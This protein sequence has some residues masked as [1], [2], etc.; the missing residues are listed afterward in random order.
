MTEKNLKCDGIYQKSNEQGILAKKLLPSPSQ[1]IDKDYNLRGE[2]VKVGVIGTEVHHKIHL[3]SDDMNDLK[4][5]LCQD[6][7]IMLL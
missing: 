6:N 7:L 5:S 2:F 3:T 4:I 1:L